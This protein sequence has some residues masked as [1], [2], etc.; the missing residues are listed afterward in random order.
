MEYGFAVFMTEYFGN[1][2]GA[3]VRSAYEF[4]GTLYGETLTSMTADRDTLEG[5]GETEYYMTGLVSQ[6]NFEAIV[7]MVRSMGFRVK[8]ANF[9]VP[10]HATES[11]D[12]Y[13]VWW[14]QDYETRKAI[15]DREDAELQRA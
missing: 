10:K 13:F 1:T 6:D 3:Q 4:A 15:W 12:A 9:T 5:E 14:N 7:K 11:L 2:T 8:E